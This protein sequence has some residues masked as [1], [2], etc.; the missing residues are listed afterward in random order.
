MPCEVL[1]RRAAR[2]LARQGAVVEL[3]EGLGAVHQAART[4]SLFHALRVPNR[5]IVYK[6]PLGPASQ[7]LIHQG[8]ARE[9]EP[10][11]LRRDASIVDRAARAQRQPEETHALARRHLF[12]LLIPVRFEILALDQVRSGGLDPLWLD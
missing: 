11:L 8:L 12:A 7:P 9:D 4:Q 2:H 5:R 10:R 3:N 6:Q 1:E